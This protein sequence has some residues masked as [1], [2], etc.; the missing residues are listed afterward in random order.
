MRYGLVT[1]KKLWV[2]DAQDQCENATLGI[3]GEAGEIAEWRKKSLFHPLPRP[4]LDHL[5]KELGDLLFYVALMNE[6]YFADSL[7]DVAKDNI[8]KLKERWPQRYADI[9]PETLTI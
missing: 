5:R 7:L 2:Q 8:R 1:R 3:V 4:T 9:D 6:L